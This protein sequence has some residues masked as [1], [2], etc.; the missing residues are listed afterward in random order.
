MILILSI[1]LTIVC[2]ACFETVKFV[3]YC[4]VPMVSVLLHLCTIQLYIGRFDIHSKMMVRLYRF[5]RLAYST[6]HQILNY[7]KLNCPFKFVALGMMLEQLHVWLKNPD[8]SNG[9]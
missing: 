9:L 8:R 6:I 7:A 2:T 1:R 3:S 4:F 5:S